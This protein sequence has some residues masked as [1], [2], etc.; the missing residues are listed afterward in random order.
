M[1]K[2]KVF[3][4]ELSYI[5][6]EN[7]K[8][9]AEKCILQLPDYFFI[10]PASTTGK[11]HPSYALGEGGLVRH[12]KAAVMLAHDLLSNDIY[13][14]IKN[15]HDEII[16]ALILHDGVKKGFNESA[17]YTAAK[18]PIY[19]SNFIKSIA[20]EN[21]IQDEFVRTICKLVETHMGQ[22]TQKVLE[23]PH[24][25]EQKFVHLCDYLASRKYIEIS[26]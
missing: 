7:I 23:P 25:T 9:F 18:H 3:E 24:S 12:T 1:D 17:E 15:L 4:K 14:R 6:N 26:F 13:E 2:L 19:A 16:V 8:V 22:W 21:D 20:F 5:E 11:Y 10:M